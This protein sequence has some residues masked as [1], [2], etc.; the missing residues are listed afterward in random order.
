[1]I[2]LISSC[3]L[4]WNIDIWTLGVGELQA[5]AENSVSSETFENWNSSSSVQLCHPSE[6]PPIL[7]A[8][9]ENFNP[10]LQLPP[11]E[12][13]PEP[14]PKP[15]PEPEPEPEPEST[16][17]VTP[18]FV[19][20]SLTP[21]FNLNKDNFGQR[22]QFVE[23]TAV[24]RLRDG[25]IL[26]FKTGFNSFE[27]PEI[28]SIRNIPIQVGW[29][30]KIDRVKFAVNGGLDF[31]NRLPVATNFNIK[32]EYPIFS[33]V[34]SDGQLQSLLVVSGVIEQGPYKFNAK[35]LESLITNWRF[36]PSVYWQIDP[37]TSFFS[38][39]QFG[40]FNDGNQEF[41]SFSRF[42]RKFGQF[43]GQFSV[44]GN[45]FTWSFQQD[46]ATENGYFSP[47]DFLVY[48][49]EVA[50]EGEIFDF[51]SCRLAA[52]LGQQRLRRKVDN[53]QTYQARCT[54]KL[55]PNIEADFGYAISNIRDR[56][57]GKT[58]F[59]SESFTGQM[60]VKF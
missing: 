34:S 5:I 50:W 11:P 53:A 28:E 52:T 10:E 24:F 25:N 39:G 33:S 60:R 51:L 42:E 12:P 47:P 54:A 1:M 46:L 31:F 19:L 48:N 4:I 38:L 30:G 58:S 57:T 13:E 43:F 45:L 29:E 32:A 22:N 14:E 18:V 23:E 8:G 20:E 41:Q 35:T 56:E 2:D 55:S 3:A 16:E 26:R 21:D 27:Q 40:F 17:P 49:A 36:R 59:T 44:A 7:M 15:K 37:N 6:P 9:P